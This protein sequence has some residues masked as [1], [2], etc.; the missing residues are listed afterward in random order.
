MWGSLD[1]GYS[2]QRPVVTADMNLASPPSKWEEEQ[3]EVIEIKASRRLKQNWTSTAWNDQPVKFGYKK[4]NFEV[5][6]LVIEEN[7][8]L[9]PVLLR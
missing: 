2:P 9:R 5:S 7:R 1:S 8:F 3:E 4:R 6:D